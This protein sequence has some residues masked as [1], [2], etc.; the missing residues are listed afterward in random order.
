VRTRACI[1]HPET[2]QAYRDIGWIDD[3]FNALRGWFARADRRVRVPIASPICA[4]SHFVQ[5]V[6]LNR[7]VQRRFTRPLRG[8]RFTIAQSAAAFG[9][10]RA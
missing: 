8:K 2:P 10:V 4:A 7:H 3:C 6:R 1:F 5:R 9:A